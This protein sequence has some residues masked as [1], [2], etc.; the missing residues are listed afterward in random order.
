MKN[1]SQRGQMPSI[2]LQTKLSRYT[3]LIA[4]TTL[5]DW[6]SNILSRSDSRLVETKPN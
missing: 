3:C 5:L 1:V 2:S 4:P 6:T